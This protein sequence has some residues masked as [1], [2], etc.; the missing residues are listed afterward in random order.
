MPRKVST[1][2]DDSMMDEVA[3]MPVSETAMEVDSTEVPK[4]KYAPASVKEM[5]VQ[6]LMIPL[7]HA[8]YGGSFLVKNLNLF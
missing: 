5:M 7:G 3:P 8:L 6:H 2:E 1:L 4:L